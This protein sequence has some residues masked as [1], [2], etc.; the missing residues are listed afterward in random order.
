M[1]DN[2]VD[3][4]IKALSL[5]F[6]NQDVRFM[7]TVRACLAVYESAKSQQMAPDKTKWKNDNPDMVQF[8]RVVRNGESGSPDPNEV[9]IEIPERPKR[10]GR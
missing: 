1:A 5:G 4:T 2:E 10:R 6:D 8:L 9:R 3:I 7:R